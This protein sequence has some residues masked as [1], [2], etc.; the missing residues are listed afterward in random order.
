[1]HFLVVDQAVNG[2]GRVGKSALAEKY[3]FLWQSMYRDFDAET[4]ATLHL[5]IR[6]NVR[7]HTAS[8]LVIYRL[9][10]VACAL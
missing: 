8:L 1:M 5:S 10:I 6:T 4:L 2:M 7:L 3:A 9:A